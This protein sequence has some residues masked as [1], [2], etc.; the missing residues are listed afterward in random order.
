[1]SSICISD[2]MNNG[3]FYTN[4]LVSAYIP[5]RTG[6]DELKQYHIIDFL[7]LFNSENKK[8][9]NKTT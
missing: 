8:P 1:M 5:K 3:F 4:N 2:V 7:I 9:L 6:F